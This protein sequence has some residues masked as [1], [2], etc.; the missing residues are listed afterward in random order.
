[1]NTPP[2]CNKYEFYFNDSDVCKQGFCFILHLICFSRLLISSSEPSICLEQVSHAIPFQSTQCNPKIFQLKLGIKTVGVIKCKASS[3]VRGVLA[4]LHTATFQKRGKAK[5]QHCPRALVMPDCKALMVASIT[6]DGTNCWLCHEA[7]W[8][9]L[10]PSLGFSSV[11][12][13]T[14]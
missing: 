4:C 3:R 11:T 6:V 2:T 5:A 1:M 12:T 7:C 14:W 10:G 9:L 13:W 8:I